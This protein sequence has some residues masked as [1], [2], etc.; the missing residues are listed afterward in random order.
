M[1]TSDERY[2]LHRYIVTD[3]MHRTLVKDWKYVE[4]MK[5]ADAFSFWFDQQI[6]ILQR[7]CKILNSQL[8][9]KGLKVL[10]LTM[11]DEY[12][13]AYTIATRGEDMELQ[14]STK[15]LKNEVQEEVQKR[16]FINSNSARK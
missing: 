8:K 14:Y 4:P 5:M 9:A 12:F 11:Q 7:E 6:K 15:A 1:I 13:C 3:L 16:L 2:L 10:H